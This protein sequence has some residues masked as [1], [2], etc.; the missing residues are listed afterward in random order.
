MLMSVKG[1]KAISIST[2]TAIKGAMTAMRVFNMVGGF[3]RD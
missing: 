1:N 3:E 2:P